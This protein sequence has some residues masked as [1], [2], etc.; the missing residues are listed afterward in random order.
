MQLV[1]LSPFAAER[2]VLLDARA[3]ETLIVVVKGTYDLKGGG[4]RLHDQQDKVRWADEYY[5]EPGKS[6]IK[7]AGE[8]APFKPATDIVLVGSARPAGKNLGQ[9]DVQLRVGKL[10]KTVTV[11]G[12]RRWERVLGFLRISKPEPFEQMPLVYERAF[13][14]VDA[15]AAEKAESEPR[16]PVGV[17]LRARKSR[18]AAE[19][20]KLPNL[21]DPA[22]RITS[23]RQR[24]KPAG[25][26]FVSPHWQPRLA[27][28]GTYDEGWQKTRSPS[29][30]T[31]SIRYSTRQRRR[32]KF[33]MGI[34]QGESQSRCLTPHLR[35]A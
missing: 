17:G 28:A 27:H 15:S 23:C 8:G 19:G 25:F 26:S 29:C 33:T 18:L 3:E 12:D 32:T 30:P 20:M 14:G 21:E 4:A 34:S 35:V 22:E 13:G 1:N 24:P 31:I 9:V 5:G 16:N 2:F 7:Y 6:S 10:R 11:L